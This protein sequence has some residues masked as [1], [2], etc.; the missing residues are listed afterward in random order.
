MVELESAANVRLRMWRTPAAEHQGILEQWGEAQRE[1]GRREDDR[2][3]SCRRRFTDELTRLGSFTDGGGS[4][5]SNICL[6]CA[7]HY[8]EVE[9]PAPEPGVEH[10]DEWTTNDDLNAHAAEQPSSLGE[11]MSEML[12]TNKEF[13]TD[14]SIHNT[15]EH[16]AWMMLAEAADALT[17]RAGL[18]HNIME[19]MDLRLLALE[20]FARNHG[21]HWAGPQG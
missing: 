5:W 17:A 16:A 6:R 11:R 21:E 18:A 7:T 20:D 9:A 1:A 3:W 15:I 10:D 8:V 2:C 19:A 14:V 4:K 12:A 13:G